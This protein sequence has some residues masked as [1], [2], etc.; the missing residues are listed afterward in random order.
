VLAVVKGRG[1]E[2]HC[3]GN[4]YVSTAGKE[5]RKALANKHG[6]AAV[7]KKKG[8]MGEENAV[9]ATERFLLKLTEPIR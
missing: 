2:H 3:R 4:D 5:L 9:A 7:G 6:T 8:A 1:P